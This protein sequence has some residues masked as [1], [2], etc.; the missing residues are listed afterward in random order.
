MQLSDLIK[1][2]KAYEKKPDIT[3]IKRAY[4]FAEKAHEGQ[5][6][7][8]GEFYIEHPLNVAYIL[9]DLKLDDITIAAALLHDVVEDTEY[10]QKDIINNFGKEIANLV[11]GMTKIKTL[12]NLS[13]EDYHAETIRKVILASV[14]D[15]R[16]ILIKLADRLHNMRTIS[17]FREEKRQRIAKDAL[18]V[19]AP[20]AHKLGIASIKWEMED[21]AFE[22]LQPEVYKEIRKKIQQSQKEREKEIEKIKKIIDEELKTTKISCDITGRPKHIY[23][24]Y[25]KMQK[26]SKSFEEIYDLTALRIITDNVRHCY[27]LLGIVHS[28]W[29]PIPKEFDDYIATPKSNMY[30]SLHTVVI[31]PINKPI[32]IQIR[33]EEMHAIAEQGIAAHWKYKGHGSDNEFDQKL[34]WMMEINELQKDSED[35]K[36]FLKMLHID[37]FEDEIFTFTPKGKV[38]ELPKSA[39]VLDFAYAVHSDL[40]NKCIAAKV[41]GLFVPLRATLKNGDRVE[42]I[43]AKNQ[44]PSRDWLK[45]VKTSKAASKIKKYITL[46]QKVPIKSFKKEEEI[47]KELEA[48]IIDVDSMSKPEILFSRCCR[49]IPGDKIV[50]FSRNMGKVNIHRNDCTA[51]KKIDSDRKKVSV[52]WVDSIGR[53]VEIKVDAENRTGL[54]AEILN[55]LIAQST[56]IKHANAKPIGNQFVECSFQME[57]S[58]LK[59]LQD[60]I[61]RLK[62]I[63]GVRHVF[64]GNVSS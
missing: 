58:G 49:P 14:K 44:H 37:F 45:I 6:R 21:L 25:R 22:Q 36:E 39:G 11:E 4:A 59:H 33:T 27:E 29:T 57:T 52:R 55:T 56:S 3:L 47:K 48:W 9:A 46:T 53:I 8:T 64:I 28:I 2:L 19:Y 15:I 63:N 1:K 60:L 51:V 38:I 35:A 17:V 5:T 16:I 42:I 20:I 62:K 23:S 43:T 61:Q 34:K 7:A 10:T 40:G 54:F 13:R 50:G 24:I 32:E 12:K 26:R 41:N 31:G 18:E 30:Q